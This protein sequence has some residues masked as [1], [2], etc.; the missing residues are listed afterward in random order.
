[1]ARGGQVES[2]SL[3]RRHLVRRTRHVA[4]STRPRMREFSDFVRTVA[5]AA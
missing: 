2:E 3:A 5:I 4:G 1:M